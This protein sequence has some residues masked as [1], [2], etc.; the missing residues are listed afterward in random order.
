[1]KIK[2]KF[3]VTFYT[4]ILYINTDKYKHVLDM[5]LYDNDCYIL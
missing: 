1:M 4:H 2:A 5:C 3:Y